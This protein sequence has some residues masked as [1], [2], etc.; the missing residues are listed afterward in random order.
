MNELQQIIDNALKTAKVLIETQ[1][2]HPDYAETVNLA[3]LYKQLITGKN[4][5]SLL[6]QFIF[7]EDN[8][9]Y[10][11]RLKL[12][13]ENL[14]ST[15]APAV[16]KFD[17][18][19]RTPVNKYFKSKTDA[20]QRHISLCEAD[21]YQGK[22]VWTYSAKKINKQALSDPN[23]YVIIDFKAFDPKKNERPKPYPV[24]FTSDEVF[25]FSYESNGELEYLFTAVKSYVNVLNEKLQTYERKEVLDFF[26][27]G[28][29]FCIEFI[30]LLDNNERELKAAPNE[31]FSKKDLTKYNVYIKRKYS[32]EK[33][34]TPIVQA[35]RLGF[36][37]SVDR[38]RI[39]ISPIDKA[40]SIGI[41]LIR[42]KSNFDIVLRIHNF[43]TPIVRGERC[44]G[45]IEK[46]ATRVCNGGVIA[47]T[48][49]KCT[50][51]GGLGKV[52]P[53][54][55]Q[56][57]MYVT[58]EDDGNGGIIPITDYIHYIPKPIDGVRLTKEEIE[59]CKREVLLAIFSSDTNR[60]DG[61]QANQ[62]GATGSPTATSMILKKDEVNNTLKPFADFK[63]DFWKWAIKLFGQFY[64][65]TPEVSFEFKTQ[66]FEPLTKE[67]VA[68]ELKI[69]TDSGADVALVSEI[70]K[71]LARMSFEPD[72][73]ALKIY[74]AKI[75]TMPLFGQKDV[76]SLLSSNLLLQRTKVAYLYFDEIW[77]ELLEDTPEIVKSEKTEIRK[78]FNAKVD[79]LVGQIK[80]EV[81]VSTALP[82]IPRN[83]SL[84]TEKE[85]TI[86]PNPQPPKV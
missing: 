57:V 41:D 13:V 33:Y 84:G 17:V 35:F 50:K 80:D 73:E 30:Q 67:D 43:P 27:W 3:K 20:I 82:T 44:P 59:N 16:S 79:D 11:Q 68:A 4:I 37:Y 53:T 54:S 60:Q 34:S 56:H 18:I 49:E 66:R 9:L 85:K 75:V 8:D 74:N 12:T 51:C 7:G 1:Y 72:S 69:M 26:Y 36:L 5:S 61:M 15:F 14:K 77:R 81:A 63:A 83:V 25:D 23:S 10:D 28:K 40:T 55:P 47:G 22:D 19:D 2:K 65:D 76:T 6:P 21:F 52:F 70:Q 31:V 78:A 24:I 39:C 46:D 42:N 86:V 32:P 62:L 71:Q 29:G 45:E 58:N 48:R 64:D 38:P